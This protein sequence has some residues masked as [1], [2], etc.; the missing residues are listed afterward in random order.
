V[1]KGMKMKLAHAQHLATAI[2]VHVDEFHTFDE[3]D[4]ITKSGNVAGH[5]LVICKPKGTQGIL[6]Q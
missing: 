6:F 3:D 4:L 2:A 1:A 5:N